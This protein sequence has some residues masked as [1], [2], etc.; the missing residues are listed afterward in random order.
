MKRRKVL[1]YTGGGGSLSTAFTMAEILLSLTIIGVVAAIT[2]PSLTGNI[3]ERTW[4]TKRKALLSRFSQAMSLM[5]S[6]NGYGV[7]RNVEQ[8][9][10][11]ISIEDTAAETF[12]TQGLSKV[13]K[14]N[15]ICDSEHLADCGIPQN[16]NDWSGNKK[17]FPK[18]LQDLNGFL[19]SAEGYGKSYSAINSKAAAFET[20]NGDSIAVF[21]NPQCMSKQEEKR[22]V[23][24]GWSQMSQKYFCANFIYD[25]NGSK[26]PNQIGK[27]MGFITAFYPTDPELVAPIPLNRPHYQSG[28]SVPFNQQ[29]SYCRKLAEDGRAANANELSSL[30]FNAQ[31][32]NVAHGNFYVYA[33]TPA[34]AEAL[35]SVIHWGTGQWSVSDDVAANPS[36]AVWTYCVQR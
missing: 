19:I 26:G 4:N 33:S 15:N 29:S 36:T 34:T 3:N 17:N 5:P 11:S 32:T 20:V 18:T 23:W 2:L 7:L 24:T 30:F 6:L 13:L 35:P 21:Y 16:Y 9:D 28:S 14:I 1:T 8:E 25:L 27:D 22:Y 12:V 10:G 31:L